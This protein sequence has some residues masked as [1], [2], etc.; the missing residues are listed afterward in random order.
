MCIAE[1]RSRFD[2]A[3]VRSKPSIRW[4]TVLLNDGFAVLDRERPDVDSKLDDSDWFNV[5]GDRVGKRHA[6]R[7]S[8]ATPTTAGT[9][10]LVFAI[11]STPA[12][13]TARSA[14][15][16]ARGTSRSYCSGPRRDRPL[17][18]ARTRAV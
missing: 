4:K 3:G 17:P 16:T 6:L 5:S 12:S 7:L 11:G 2:C 8:R 1:R 10:R 15:S 18:Q 14:A 13:T 9:I